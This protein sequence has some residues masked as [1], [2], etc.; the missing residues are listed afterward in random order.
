[1]MNHGDDGVQKTWN[2][3]FARLGVPTSGGGEVRGQIFRWP[4]NNWPAT[5][6]FFKIPQTRMLNYQKIN[7]FFLNFLFTVKNSKT[8]ANR[9]TMFSGFQVK[10]DGKSLATGTV[11]HQGRF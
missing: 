5:I 10:L 6:H 11:D 9:L 4:C 3:F 8:D 2:Q 7:L 1:M